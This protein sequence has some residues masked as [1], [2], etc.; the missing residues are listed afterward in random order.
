[1]KY[2]H[3][4]LNDPE[5]VATLK[6]KDEELDKLREEKADLER[7]NTHLEWERD[8]HTENYN[9][10]SKLSRI[11]ENSASYADVIVELLLPPY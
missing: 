5:L 2:S 8:R 6:E 7:R 11:Y 9:S 4:I 10:L 3:Y 1:M